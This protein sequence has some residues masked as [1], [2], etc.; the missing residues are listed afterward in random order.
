MFVVLD[1]VTTM[2][3]DLLRR[4]RFMQQAQLCTLTT[5][6]GLARD[7][8][9]LAAGQIR[10]SAHLVHGCP[11][12]IPMR[13][14]RSDVARLKQPPKAS[15]VGWSLGAGRFTSQLAKRPSGRRPSEF[16]ISWFNWLSSETRQSTTSSGAFAV[17]HSTPGQEW[18]TRVHD[19]GAGPVW[20][21]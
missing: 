11:Q 7:T 14:G 6:E 20:S 9:C 17:S 5:V 13:V 15:A 12:G 19:T 4:Q 1:A 2:D 18:L 16:A 10:E 8:A 21:V 3:L